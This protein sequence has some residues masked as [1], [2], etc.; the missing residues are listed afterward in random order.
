MQTF[1]RRGR[2]LSRQADR[3]LRRR[4]KEEEAVLARSVD[5]RTD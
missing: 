1:D 4:E 5:G 3:A 2:L